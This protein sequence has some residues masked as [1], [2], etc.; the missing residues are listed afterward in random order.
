MLLPTL[1]KK[2]GA[3][4]QRGDRILRA[5]PKSELRRVETTDKHNGSQMKIVVQVEVKGFFG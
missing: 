1:K 3:I 4:V 5:Y 2:L